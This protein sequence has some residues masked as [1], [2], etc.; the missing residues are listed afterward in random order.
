MY[1][2]PEVK[3]RRVCVKPFRSVYMAFISHIIFKKSKLGHF[4]LLN[5]VSYQSEVSF[6]QSGTGVLVKQKGKHRFYMSP[7]QAKEKR[8][9]EGDWW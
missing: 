2:T 5:R 4:N 8:R 3:H 1:G 7:I 9:Q 6:A